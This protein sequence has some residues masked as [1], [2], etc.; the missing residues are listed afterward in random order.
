MQVGRPLAAADRRRA[1]EPVPGRSRPEPL[2][3][4]LPGRTRG[5]ST[6]AS[7]T[8]ARP[9]AT[10]RSS[11]AR[12]TSSSDG[13]PPQV[14]APDLRLRQLTARTL[15]AAMDMRDPVQAERWEAADPDGFL[16][17]REFLQRTAMAAGLAASAGLALGPETLIA[18][19]ARRQ[20]RAPLPS[21]RDLPIDTFVVLMMENRSFDH[22]AGWLPGADGKQARPELRRRRR[23]DLP[24]PS[25]RAR[26]PGLRLQRPRPLVGGRPRAAER[27]QVRRLP[28]GRQRRL[29]DRL[30]RREG[31]PVPG[32]GRARRSRPATASS[33]RS[34]ARRSRTASTCTPRSRTAQVD[35]SLPAAGRLP[36]RLPGLDDLRGAVGQERLEPLLLH[37]RAGLGALGPARPGPLEPRRGVLPALRATARCRRCRS[38]TRRSATRAAAP[39]ATSTR[40]ATSAPATRSCPTSCTRSWSR[41]S[42]SAARCSSSTTSGAASSTTSPPPRVPDDRGTTRPQQ[43]LR[44]D[45]LP[46]P[47]GHRLAVR[48]PR[49]RRPH[50]AGASSRS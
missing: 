26:L 7:T 28:E 29:R 25:A 12:S 32:R 4:E 43:G 35:N 39:R 30:L 24:D 21:P 22:F 33:A 11:G 2:R 49:P 14:R 3:R 34:S 46:H 5:R 9:R 45:G 47:G 23:Q 1:L 13:Q 48:A 16:R 37:R 42:G 17:R 20:R 31:R 41:R 44:P 15:R 18:E 19:A 27:R 6:C 38:S 50:A 8:S 36:D 10:R 40:T